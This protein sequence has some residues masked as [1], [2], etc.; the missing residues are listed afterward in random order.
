M[1]RKT[2]KRSVTLEGKGLHSGQPVSVTLH[3]AHVGYVLT[4]DGERAPAIASSVS[5]TARCTQIGKYS[6]VEHVIS[7]LAGLQ[8]TDCEI[9]V[10]GGEMPALDGSSLPF[11]QAMVEAGFT[12]LGEVSA[13]LFERVFVQQEGSK[14]AIAKG[15]G[16]WKCIFDSGERWPGRQEYEVQLSEVGYL[17]D[18]APARTFAFIEEVDYLREKGLGAGLS[19]ESCLI[20]GET[21]YQNAARFPDEPVRHKLLDLIGDLALSGVPLYEIDVV[22][23]RPGHAINVAAALKLGQHAKV[24]RK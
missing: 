24:C 10:L 22:A 4:G 14:I 15:S 19:E 12:E 20:L 3:P 9:E 7:A 13:T 2:L 16:R 18:I 11:A 17:H 5:S 1:T 23:E 21:G 6:T 8:V